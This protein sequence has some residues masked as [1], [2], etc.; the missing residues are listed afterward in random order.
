ME[1]FDFSFAQ[2]CPNDCVSSLHST[3]PFIEG[4]GY[5]GCPISY[6]THLFCT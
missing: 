4:C 6:S 3:S 2:E 5:I 1:Y